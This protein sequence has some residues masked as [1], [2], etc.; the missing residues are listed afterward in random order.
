MLITYEAVSGCTEA[1][2]T[3]TRTTGTCIT[4]VLITLEAGDAGQAI[5]WSTINA[6]EAGLTPDFLTGEILPAVPPRVYTSLANLRETEPVRTSTDAVLTFFLSGEVDTTFGP[7]TVSLCEQGANPYPLSNDITITLQRETPTVEPLPLY[8]G[9]RMRITAATTGLSDKLFVHMYEPNT[10]P[11][12]S[13]I[14]AFSHIASLTDLV[15]YPEDTPDL[16]NSRYYRKNY[17]DFIVRTMQE[18]EEAWEL[19]QLDVIDLKE[20][21][22]ANNVIGTSSTW[23]MP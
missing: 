19:L 10:V 11:V 17:V 14:S 13:A 22:L 21:V 8:S 3:F 4:R 2:G 7:V 18:A 1:S 12:A 5:D 16:E 15:E 23:V 20:V 6:G 9:Y